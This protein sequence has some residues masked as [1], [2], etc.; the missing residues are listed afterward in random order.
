MT[1]L[2]RRAAAILMAGA[3]TAGLAACGGNSSSGGTN[4]ADGADSGGT[5]GSGEVVKLVVWGVGTADTDDCNEVAEAISA[6]TREEIGA[7]I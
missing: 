7:E 5:S 2:W 4:S 3:M 6:I 1:K